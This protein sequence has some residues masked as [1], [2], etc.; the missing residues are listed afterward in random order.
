MRIA[1]FAPLEEPVPPLLYGGT[2]R[3]VAYLSEELKRQGHHVTL[4]ASADSRTTA[5]LVPCWP[6]GLRLHPPSVDPMPEVLQLLEGMRER[7]LEFDILHFHNDFLQLPVFR[8][9]RHVVTTL[10]FRADRPASQPFFNAC[11]GTPLVSCSSDQQ[12]RGP[13]LNWV[14]AVHLGLPPALLRPIR[15][16]SNR[17]LAFLGRISPEK[18]PDRAIEIAQ[19]VGMPLRIAGKIPERDRAY[20][21]KCIRPLLGRP[22]VEFL[23]ELA[24]PQKNAFLANARALLFP[25][26]W[27]EPFG[28]VLIETFACGTPVIAFRRGAVPEVVDH[29]LTGFVVDDV[30]GAV[31]KIAQLDDLDRL[32]IRHQFERRFQVSQM[33]RKYLDIYRT[34]NQCAA[35]RDQGLDR[36]CRMALDGAQH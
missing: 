11:Q 15:R 19:R 25:I 32:Q 4:F 12:R 20:Y 30:A 34:L 17:Y 24:Q 18:G 7:L 23:G 33:A 3:V 10:H 2:E 16:P 28:T 9:M 1:Q 31:Q 26:D 36:R 14:G 22:G 6:R 13:H 35:A 8:G 29:G 27:A 5:D 21:E